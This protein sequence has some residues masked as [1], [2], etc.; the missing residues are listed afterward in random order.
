MEE[1]YLRPCYHVHLLPPLIIVSVQVQ[2]THCLQCKKHHRAHFR[3][4]DVL[5]FHLGELGYYTFITGC[6]YEIYTEVFIIVY[7]LLQV[8]SSKS[9]LE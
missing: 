5:R 7:I 1:I 2:G 6:Q 4:V 9:N 8:L 3:F